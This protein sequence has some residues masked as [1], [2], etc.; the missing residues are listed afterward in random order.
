[1]QNKT[2]KFKLFKIKRKTPNTQLRLCCKVAEFEF[3]K[4]ENE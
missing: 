1:M 3:W 4:I 2:Q